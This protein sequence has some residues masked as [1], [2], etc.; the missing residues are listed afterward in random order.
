MP[1]LPALSQ[2]EASLGIPVTSAAACTVRAM[3]KQMNL[4]PVAPAAGAV[5]APALR[6]AA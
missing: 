4:E 2:V 3:L 5:L 6:P 1:S